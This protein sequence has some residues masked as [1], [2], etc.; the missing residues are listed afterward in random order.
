[1]SK[2]KGAKSRSTIRILIVG[3]SLI[4]RRGLRSLLEEQRSFRLVGETADCAVAVKLVR[5]LRPDILLLD[6]DMP[7]QWA[8]AVLRKCA[9]LD[10]PTRIIVLT[11]HIDQP[12]IV[13]A[14]RLGARG[15]VEKDGGLKFKIKAIRAVYRNECWAN[16]IIISDAL[17]YLRKIEETRVPAEQHTFGLTLREREILPAVVSGRTNKEIAHEFE[18]SEETLKHHLTHIYDK[19]GVSNRMELAFYAVNHFLIV[20]APAV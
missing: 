20:S 8:L 18:I 7:R 2:E 11:S 13:E 14:L 6:F 15:I 3:I 17:D 5:K 12:G 19:L 1:M 9:S 4:F 10:L 16:K